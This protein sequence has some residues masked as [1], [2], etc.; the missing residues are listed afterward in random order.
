MSK[1]NECKYKMNRLFKREKGCV[2]EN[3]RGSFI[4][5]KCDSELMYV[6]FGW[7]FKDEIFVSKD[8]LKEVT[9]FLRENAYDPYHSEDMLVYVDPTDSKHFLKYRAALPGPVL[10]K[11][12]AMNSCN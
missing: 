5:G 12:D 7:N 6:H 1:I 8:E 2:S 3:D 11:E 9:E 4:I 10:S